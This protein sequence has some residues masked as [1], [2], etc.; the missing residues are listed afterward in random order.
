MLRWFLIIIVVA[1]AGLMAYIRLAPADLDSIHQPS[2]PADIGDRDDAGSFQATRQITTPGADILQAIDVV[3][4]RTPRTKR[5]AGDVEDGILTYETRSLIMGFPDYTTVW[6][7]STIAGEGPHVN[8]RG[9]LRFGQSDMGVNKA[10]IQGW[11]AELGPLIVA[12]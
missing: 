10:R 6:I 3:I 11:L 9:Q 7:D 5:I 8:I 2:Y 12:P 4:L 1:V